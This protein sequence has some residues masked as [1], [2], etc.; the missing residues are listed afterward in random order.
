[1]FTSAEYNQAAST[2]EP[3]VFTKDKIIIAGILFAIAVI[4]AYIL[5]RRTDLIAPDPHSI[6]RKDYSS[7]FVLGELDIYDT[8]GQNIAKE[9]SPKLLELFVLLFIKTFTTNN[10]QNSSGITSD[11]LSVLLWPEYSP[12]QAKN[13]RNVTLNKLREFLK[14]IDGIELVFSNRSWKLEID[15]ELYIDYV[16]LLFLIDNYSMLSRENIEEVAEIT[17]RGE[18]FK[19]I[20]FNWLDGLK[21]NINNTLLD[22]LLKLIDKSED[23]DLSLRLCESIFALDS[24]NERALFIKLKI[25]NQQ[26]KHSI[27][28]TVYDNYCNEYKSLYGESFKRSVQDLLNS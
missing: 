7:I 24:V 27:L 26:G 25:L 8:A 4:F 5:S 2:T 15:T 18:V 16:R 11:K 3:F 6:K 14:R 1:V 21:T 12:K 10:H 13:V 9:L 20:S 23:V 22:T 28:K 17:S 19:F